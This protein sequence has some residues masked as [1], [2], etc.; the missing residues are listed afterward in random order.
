M[1]AFGVI[2]AS[3][4]LLSI[5]GGAEWAEVSSDFSF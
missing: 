5:D 2:P 3:G 1:T 4:S